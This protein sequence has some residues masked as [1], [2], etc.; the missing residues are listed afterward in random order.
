MNKL[1]IFFLI[2]FNFWFEIYDDFYAILQIVKILVI[3]PQLQVVKSEKKKKTP[4][5]F[6]KFL[7]KII[8][9]IK[10]IFNFYY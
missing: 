2:I 4:P 3:K 10:I 8:V 6:V 7:N 1:I 9:V 5:N